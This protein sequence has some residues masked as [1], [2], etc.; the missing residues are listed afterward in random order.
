MYNLRD[1]ITKKSKLEWNLESIRCISHKCRPQFCNIVI[2]QNN[3]KDDIIFDINQNLLVNNFTIYCNEIPSKKYNILQYNQKFI[4][5]D[6]SN[7]YVR[8]EN[9]QIYKIKLKYITFGLLLYFNENTINGE[10]NMIGLLLLFYLH[11]K[12]I[13]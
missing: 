2:D 7:N 9:Q 12:F 3:S 6:S 11:F 13:L 1:L 10:L 5:S 4:F 8:V